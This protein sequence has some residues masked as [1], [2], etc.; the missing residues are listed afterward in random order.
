LSAAFGFVSSFFGIGGGFLYVPALIYLLKFPIHKAKAISLFILTISAFSGSVTR[1]MT[2][3]FHQGV[4]R[5]I[6]L[7]IGAI[8]GA[9]MGA[10][11]S[12]RLRSVWIIKSLAV[13][14][15]LVGIRL[16]VSLR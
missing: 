6:A 16:L 12:R 15:G 2:G 11:L 5:A 9:Q 14:L 1:I 4:R 3:A 13:A 7:S 10:N 8:I